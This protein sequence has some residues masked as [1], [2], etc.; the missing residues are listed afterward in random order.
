MYG[1]GTQTAGAGG[2][3]AY[4]GTNAHWLVF[5]GVTLV[6][7]GIALYQLARRRRQGAPRP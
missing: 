6:F 3:L 1:T 2:V 7:A 5:A 4:T